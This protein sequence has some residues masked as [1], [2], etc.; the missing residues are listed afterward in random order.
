MRLS[1]KSTYGLRAMLN[2]AMNG[3]GGATSITDI[4]K[5][6]G[7]SVAYLEQLLNKLMHKGLI[8]S[9][10]G[11]KGGY[12]LSRKTAKI[13]VSDI[14][15]SLEGD[16]YPVHCVTVGKRPGTC[17]RSSGCVP[18]LVWLKLARSIEKCL[19]SITLE[20]LCTEARK[21]EG[22]RS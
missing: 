8:D 1:T 7:I 15:R 4:S 13:T 5:D 10:R 21:I 18:K 22:A 17:K 9:V 6:E 11:P 16:I 3:A 12:V 2:I 20:D 19:D 14:V